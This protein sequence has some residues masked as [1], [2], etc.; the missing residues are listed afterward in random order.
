MTDE[1]ARAWLE[2]HREQLNQLIL[3]MRLIKPTSLIIVHANIALGI[4]PDHALG[5]DLR[6]AHGQEALRIWSAGADP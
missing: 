5:F 2:E 6:R 3:T 1:E 4:I